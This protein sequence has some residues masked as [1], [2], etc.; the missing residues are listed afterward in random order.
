MFEFSL[1]EH[2]D[3]YYKKNMYLFSYLYF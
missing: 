2:S 3:N 1:Y